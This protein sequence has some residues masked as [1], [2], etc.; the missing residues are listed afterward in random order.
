MKNLTS[1]RLKPETW[2][3]IKA[4]LGIFFLVYLASAVS[5]FLA[6]TAWEYQ[7]GLIVS[8]R[9]AK[10]LRSGFGIFCLGLLFMECK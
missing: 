6:G 7:L 2:R 4:F 10:G 3:M 9:L 8:E 1:Q 5:F